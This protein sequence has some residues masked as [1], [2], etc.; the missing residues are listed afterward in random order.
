[1]EKL[2]TAEELAEYLR[3]TPG[4]I[5]TWKSMGRIPADCVRKI[6]R[7]VLFVAEKIEEWLDS[8]AS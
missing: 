7:K 2:I 5:Y 8:S 1:M 6:G 4:T 3:S